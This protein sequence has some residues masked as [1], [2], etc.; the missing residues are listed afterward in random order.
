MRP[1]PP[2]R[3]VLLGA[4]FGLLFWFGLGFFCGFELEVAW[5]GRF[6]IC[7]FGIFQKSS[8]LAIQHQEKAALIWRLKKEKAGLSFAFARYPV[9]RPLP[10]LRI[11]HLHR[12][13]LKRVR[14]HADEGS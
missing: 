2:L 4:C 6:F 10:R 8:R 7:S 13:M 14:R 1:P 12:R 5:K 3:R 9:F 11:R